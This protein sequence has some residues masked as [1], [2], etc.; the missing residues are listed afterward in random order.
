MTGHLSAT[1]MN[2]YLQCGL[3]YRFQY[4]DQL[5]KP[6]KASGLALGSA[7]HSALAWLHKEIMRGR[8]VSLEKLFRTFEADW[9]SQSLDSEIRYRDGEHEAKVVIKGKEILGLYL[10]SPIGEPK[11]VEVPFLVPLSHPF[12]GE[13]LDLPLEGFIDLIEKDGTV[14]EFKTSSRTL[15]PSLIGK[16]PKGLRLVDF[17]KLRSPKIEVFETNKTREDY[18]RLFLTA[19]EI[20]KGIRSGVFV[21]RPSFF[22]KDCDYAIP[23]KEWKGN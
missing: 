4:I 9:F 12:N 3:K 23:C 19:R 20:L 1:Q 18:E 10:H 22:C 13:T 8:E 14:V 2:L 15:D 5:P 16:S 21:P 11:G 7:V 17:V 6:F